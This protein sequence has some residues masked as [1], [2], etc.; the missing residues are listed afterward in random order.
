MN[1]LRGKLIAVSASLMLAAMLAVTLGIYFMMRA[2]LIDRMGAEI[3]GVVRANAASTGEWISS[4]SLITQAAA[5]ATSSTDPLP[6]LT[7]A[8]QAGRFDVFYVAYPDKRVV[9]SNNQSLPA[10]YDATTRPWYTEAA[11]SK[12]PIMTSPYV[13]ASNGKLVVT[14]AYAAHEGADLKGVVAG[15]ITLTRVVEQVLSVKFSASGYALL[16]D[17]NGKILVHPQKELMQ[18]AST[19]L[20]P[21]LTADMVDKIVKHHGSTSLDVQQV[22]SLVAMFAVPGTDLV[23]GAVIDK[24]SA[25]APLNKLLWTAFGILLLALAVVLPVLVTVLT[26]M[27]GRLAKLRDLMKDISTGGGDLTLALSVSG[28]DEIAET[29]AAFNRFLAT[30]RTMFIEVHGESERLSGGVTNI[31]ETVIR[32]AQHSTSLSDTAA[33]NAA[34]IEEITVSVAHIADS[35]ATANK[36]VQETGRMSRDGAGVIA[37]VS[38]E[39]SRS[40]ESV[41]SLATMIQTVSGRANEISGI[42]NVIK[43]IAD[44]T[45]LLALNAAI[46]AARAG[47]QGRGFAVVADEVRKLA[48]RT[49]KAT[50][51]IGHMI[52]GMGDDTR[53]AFTGMESTIETVT[54]GAQASEEAARQMEAIQKK[55]QDAVARIDEIAAST[56]EQQQATTQMAQSAEQITNRMH[57]NDAAIQGVRDTL[58][59]LHSV[60]DTMRKLISGFRL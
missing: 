34:T 48:E 37:Q 43:E 22:P 4:R 20:S 35:A 30:L 60:S 18:K 7:Q 47:E 28:N 8:T 46:E 11:A 32:L 50:L 36:L 45:N 19:E 16:L 59:G 9:F 55:M 17:K 31:N 5:P 10:G 21:E 15:D 25:L 13:D 44:Q 53:R 58:S 12:D 56:S 38:D 33:S 57:E 27:L 1:T 51:E 52:T 14:F 41:K 6:I 40:S 29:S 3:G 42:V 23:L 39:F 49:A 2:E 54:K 26:R 24:A